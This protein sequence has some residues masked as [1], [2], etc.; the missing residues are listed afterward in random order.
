VRPSAERGAEGATGIVD[1]HCHLTHPQLVDEVESVVARARQ[2]GLTAC[3]TIGTG[4]DDARRAVELARDFC[5]FVF[6]SAGIDPFSAHRLGAGFDD[7]LQRLEGLLA[8][9]RFVAL[10]EI[11][12]D[13]HYDLDPPG[14]QSER[15]ERQLELAARRDLPVVIHV[16]EAHGDMAAILTRHPQNRGVIHSFTAGPE[17]AERYLELGWYLGFNGVV[18]FKNAEEVRRAAA[19]TPADRLLVETDSPYLAPVPRRGKRCEPTF[20]T[21]TLRRLAE[22]RTTTTESLSATTTTNAQRLFGLAQSGG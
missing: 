11:G 20:V 18:T 10:G 1:T 3:V 15:F 16:R 12:L 19:L 9:E 22:L 21:H 13:Y 17:E 8:E 6:C 2:A 5:G 4:V 14:L 7:E